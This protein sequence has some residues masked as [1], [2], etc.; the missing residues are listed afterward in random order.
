VTAGPRHLLP[1]STCRGGWS[2]ELPEGDTAF[3]FLSSS[4]PNRNDMDLVG[5]RAGC[6]FTGFAGSSFNGEKVTV[7]A[8][9]TSERWVVFLRCSCSLHLTSCPGMSSTSTWTRI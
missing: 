6:S 4:W 8:P 3:P 7:R 2:L 9:H 5:V 1:S